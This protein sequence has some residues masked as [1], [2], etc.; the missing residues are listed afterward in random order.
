MK[1]SSM[2]LVALAPAMA[3]L[4]SVAAAQSNAPVVAVLAF[5]GWPTVARGVRGIVLV[6]GKSEYAE[7]ARALGA[8]SWRVIWLRGVSTWCSR[9]A[10]SMT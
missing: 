7:A 1:R 5:V 9:P 10:T 3:F 8:G 6:E 2:F 4:P